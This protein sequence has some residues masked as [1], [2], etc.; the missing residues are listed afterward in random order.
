MKKFLALALVGLMVSSAQALNI[1]MVALDGPN[2]YTG[3]VPTLANGSVGNN[4][5]GA[6]AGVKPSAGGAGMTVIGPSGTARMGIVI[7]LLDGTYDQDGTVVVNPNQLAT[8]TLFMNQIAN[9]GVL[10]IVDLANVQLTAQNDAN[11]LWHTEAYSTGMINWVTDLRNGGT[12]T[13]TAPLIEDYHLISFDDEA[14]CPNAGGHLVCGGNSFAGRN[15][16][17]HTVIT[18]HGKVASTDPTQEA[19]VSW[20]SGLTEFFNNDSDAYGFV[21]AAPANHGGSS[22]TPGGFWFPVNGRAKGNA[23]PIEV[24]MVPEPATLSLLGLAGLAV[25]RRR[26][27]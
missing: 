19:R 2:A 27:K 20:D 11:E 25:M 5:S 17:L 16:W 13:E 7:Q 15:L 1:Y 4:T 23:F 12:L 14:A 9:P 21:N 22:N 3:G 6:P 24:V 8:A 26:R 10:G 18:V